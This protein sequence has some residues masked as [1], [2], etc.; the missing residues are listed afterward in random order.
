MDQGV[1]KHW[2]LFVL[3]AGVLSFGVLKLAMKPSAIW[4]NPEDQSYEMI[5]PR[6]V[7][8]AY[9]LSGRR[10]VRNL[11]SLP[12]HNQMASPAV[13]APGLKTPPMTAEAKAKEAKAKADAAKKTAELARKK[14]RAQA[15]AAKQRAKMA[16]RTV[17]APGTP[18]SGLNSPDGRSNYAGGAGNFAPNAGVDEVNGTK[19][20]DDEKK[21]VLSP[22]QWRSLLHAQPTT[23]NALDFVAAFHAGDIDSNTFYQISSELLADTSTD[24]QKMGLFILKQDTSSKSFSVL[25]ANYKDQ[26]PEPMKSDI[27]SAIKAYSEASK[28]SVLNKVLLSSDGRSVQM[29]TS[30]LKQVV[31]AQAHSTGTMGRDGRSPGSAPIP[32]SQF[33]SLVPTLRRLASS[34]DSTVAQQAQALIDSIQAMK[35]AA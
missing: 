33:E 29:A 21:D 31:D 10:V 22:A 18:M 12:T 2:P 6:S 1:L 15:Q 27:Y 26:T 7:S 8:Q 17:S 9:D 35:A 30:L 16:V 20:N 24:R 32:V 13:K 5:R 4:L 23:K 11:H 34:Q 25:V 19:S 28:F 3:A 14:A